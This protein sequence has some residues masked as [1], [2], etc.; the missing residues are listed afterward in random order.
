MP[1]YEY[2]CEKCDDDFELLLG[3]GSGDSALNCP[4]CGS[5]NLKKLFSK[6][7]AHSKG[8]GGKV[9]SSGPSSCGGCSSSSCGS[10]SS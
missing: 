6:F 2:Y 9:S 10:C 1:I 3:V 4:R 5:K 7:A 8:T